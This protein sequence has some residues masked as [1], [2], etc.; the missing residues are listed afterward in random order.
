M[1]AG[2]ADVRC[3]CVCVLPCSGT[4]FS[5]LVQAG[6]SLLGVRC[7]L[8]PPTPVA[9]CCVGGCADCGGAFRQPDGGANFELLE[10]G[11]HPRG[12]SCWRDGL[13][14]ALLLAHCTCTPPQRCL[15][16]ARAFKTLLAHVRIACLL[17]AAGRGAEVLLQCILEALRS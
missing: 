4:A 9:L 11:V 15:Q 14:D 6:C 10:D 17:L 16:A 1:G 5:C 3:V 13:A 12:E 8:P 2:A 7:K